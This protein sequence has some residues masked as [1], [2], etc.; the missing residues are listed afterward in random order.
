MELSSKRF[1]RIFIIFALSLILFDNFII[2]EL[3][4]K[5]SYYH[6]LREKVRDFKRLTRLS[7][8]LVK[9]NSE[10]DSLFN[11]HHEELYFDK[12][13]DDS[14]NLLNKRKFKK[15]TGFQDIY[16]N[17]S[18]QSNVVIFGDLIQEFFNGSIDTLV[19]PFDKEI[20]CNEIS[21]STWCHTWNL[22]LLIY[23]IVVSYEKNF[24]HNLTKDEYFNLKNNTDVQIPASS[25]TIINLIY[26]DPRALNIKKY[27][28]SFKNEIFISSTKS[29]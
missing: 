5:S 13:I 10:V 1:A 9:S 27:L 24:F 16:R 12:M 14:K 7:S 11:K 25:N 2:Y 8:N 18:K 4:I 28:F 26:E 22:D 23:P 3:V 21:E 20:Y 15:M 19:V 29:N 6:K 17:S